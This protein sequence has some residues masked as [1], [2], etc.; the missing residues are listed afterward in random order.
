MKKE[1][2][3]II[4]VVAI[5]AVIAIVLAVIFLNQGPKTNLKTIEMGE[6]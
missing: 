6:D 5:I 1:T 4:A 2:K 3:I